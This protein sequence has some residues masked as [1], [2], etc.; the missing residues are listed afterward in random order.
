MTTNAKP[1]LY[2]LVLAGGRSTRMGTDKAML[3]YHGAP[4]C[5]HLY[6]LLKQ[7]CPSTYV[8][9]R[10]DQPT[11]TQPGMPVIHDEDRYRGPFNGLLSAHRAYPTVAWLVVAVDLPLI[12]R[13][14]LQRLITH[15]QTDQVATALATR[16][17]G[18]PE[19]LCAIWEPTGLQRAEAWL[20]SQEKTC[21]RKFLIREK[22]PLC[23]PES[24]QVL[25]NAN[26]E[27]DY[28]RALTLLQHDEH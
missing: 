16:A 17:S 13:M 11:Q 8:S 1:P 19:P 23:F 20:A 3:R 21:P 28:R 6:T 22:A 10:N 18:L 27:E 15:R 2:G 7:V 26:D 14:S 25:M 24:D 9:L 12:D 5:E 4:H